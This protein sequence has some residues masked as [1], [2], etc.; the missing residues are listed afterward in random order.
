ML[1][2][3]LED[4]WNK[5]GGIERYTFCLITHLLQMMKCGLFLYILSFHTVF[6]CWI[7]GALLVF[8]VCSRDV[9]KDKHRQLNHLS[10]CTLFWHKSC[11]KSK[12][13][14]HHILNESFR[15]WI[16]ACVLLLQIFP[17]LPNLYWSLSAQTQLLIFNQLH[18]T[19]ALI[20]PAVQNVS[21]P[22]H[23]QP[24]SNVCGQKVF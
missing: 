5:I 13:L 11:F 1:S 10:V 3:I 21:H 8:I 19:A 17:M 20:S 9:M 4:M 22:L 18:I 23:T 7:S 6:L 2:N 12:K 16:N 15:A 14:Q 24:S